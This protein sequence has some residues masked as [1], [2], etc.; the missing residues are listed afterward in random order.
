[1]YF[2]ELMHVSTSVDLEISADTM[3]QY[4]VSSAALK[5]M[6]HMLSDELDRGGKS[7]YPDVIEARV[8]FQ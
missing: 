6:M 4:I 8:F 3:H 1:M 7:V 5:T 2:D